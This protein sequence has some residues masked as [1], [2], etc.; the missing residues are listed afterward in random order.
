MI[1]TA[2]YA[3]GTDLE[4]MNAA[5]GR[6]WKGLLA[7]FILLGA[8]QFF[9]GARTRGLIWFAVGCVGLPSLLLVYTMPFVPGKAAVL[10]PGIGLLVWLAVLYD[11]YRPIRPLHWW[12][13]ITLIIVSL[14]LSV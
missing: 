8:G 11:S 5:T 3:D 9:S 13:W 6:P 4:K 12:G 7:S 2:D 1:S 10:L 14:G